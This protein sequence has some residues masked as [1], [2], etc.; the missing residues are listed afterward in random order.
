M[1]IKGAS[2]KAE[3]TAPMPLSDFGIGFGFRVRFQTRSVSGGFPYS[4][5]CLP[6]EVKTFFKYQ[7]I[8]PGWKSQSF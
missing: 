4:A 3:K 2:A 6:E 1:R 8:K 5:L 7:C